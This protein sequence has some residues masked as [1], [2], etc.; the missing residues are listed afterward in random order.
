MYQPILDRILTA[1]NTGDLNA[2]DEVVAS[3]FVRRAP[4]TID[5]DANGLEELKT[6][7][8]QFRT[9]FPDCHV[10]LDEVHFLGNRCFA[11]WTFTGTNTGPGEFPITGKSVNVKGTTFATF[12]DN[13]IVEEHVMFDVMGFM[14][15]LGLL[16]EP[17]AAH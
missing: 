4:A 5:S 7:I 11:R 15:Q 17:E 3:N 6:R 2:L 8:T 12:R 9:S 13:Q 1:W 10:A 14:M 16:Q